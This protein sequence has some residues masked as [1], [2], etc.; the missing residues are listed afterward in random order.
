MLYSSKGSSCLMLSWYCYWVKSLCPSDVCSSCCL[1]RIQRPAWGSF[2][3]P[4]C[5]L[6]DICL[7]LPV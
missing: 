4:V 3:L 5:I 7:I 2:C 6:P 1:S